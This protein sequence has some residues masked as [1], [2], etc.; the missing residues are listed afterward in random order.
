MKR[1]TII[2]SLV[3]T[4]TLM[5]NPISVEKI[6]V[7]TT[8]YEDESLFMAD[9]N[10]SKAENKERFT[11]KSIAK[12]S[13]HAN[14]NPY[15]VIAFS[16]SVN[17]TPVDTIG[18]NEP[19]F[20][21]PIRI[22][23]KSQSG[24]GGV[25]MINSMPLSSNP[26]GGKHMVD[27][28]NIA[29]IDL[30]KGYLPVDKN[31]G[32]SSLIGKVDLNVLSAKKEAGA[33]ISQSFGSE[34]FKR[35][36]LRFDTG[37]FGDFSAFGSISVISNDKYKGDGDLQ[38]VNGMLGLT[39]EPNSS[40]K[41]ELYA[42]RNSD[43]HHNYDSLSYAQTQNLGVY[44][45]KDFGTV[46]PTTANDVDYYDWNRQDFIT[47][48][49]FADILY[50][51]TSD[52]TITFKP[53]YKQ[54]EGEIFF[55]KFDATP[56]KQGVVNWQMDHDLYGAVAAYEHSFSQALKS[57]IG[58]WY[59]K[60]LPPGPPTDR[61]FYG[62]NATGD[63]FFK[64]YAS[65]ADVDHHVLQSPF[66]EISGDINNF[67]YSVGVQYQNFKLSSI[68][69]Y[70]TDANTSLDYDTAIATSTLDTWGSV[71][72][73]TFKTWLPSLYAAYKLDDLSS[74]YLDY[75]RSYGFDVNLYPTYTSNY[76]NFKGKGITL[77]QLWNDLELET[78]DNIDLGYKTT[79][80]AV[81][82]QPSLFVSFVSNKQANVYDTA[83]DVS[84]P[85][86]LGDAVGYGAEFSA[87]GALREDLEFMMGLSYNS[88]SFDQDFTTSATTTS[89]IKGNQ[90]PDAPKVMAKG[91][92]SYYLDKWTFT[93]SVRYTSSRYGDVENTQK[94]DAFTVVDLDVSYK[95]KGFL[96]SKNT[97]FRLSATNISDEEYIATI[98][99]PDNV[100]A[101]STT[102]STYQTGAPRMVFFSANLRY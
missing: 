65:L 29:S 61:R 1:K 2:L 12:L 52:D 96:G 54:D 97:M 7:D 30:L 4:A 93:P 39:Y 94:V 51:P 11:S 91:A 15:T 43:E 95:A 26:G 6:V 71:D 21:D 56:A 24:P 89:N 72:A 68:K 14:M 101:A 90:L 53:Y 10:L 45:D 102:S 17:F 84:Y 25:Y 44:F 82:L 86:N 100:L 42:I 87:Y 76:A 41:A 77:Q 79:V 49:I 92:L 18:S 60:Q 99:T 81:T 48:N 23:G 13:T 9:S 63:L 83:L 58:Y 88:Y 57:K 38:R 34:D 80:G 33:T 59:H 5:A 16:P 32:F 69:N 47:T 98:N 55:S 20:H 37:K 85:A 28:E 35:T 3:A 40:F 22:R 66:V 70:L 36:F 78:S 73:K 64:K 75:S 62:V 31:L 27:M 8:A 74:V 46:K 67:I 19:S 50:K